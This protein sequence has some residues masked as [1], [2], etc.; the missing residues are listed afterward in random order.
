MNIMKLHHLLCAAAMSLAL[1]NQDLREFGFRLVQA[2]SGWGNSE[3]YP[4]TD[5]GPFG[6]SA[7]RAAAHKKAWEWL[8][9]QP[10]APPKPGK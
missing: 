3:P 7:V 9:K 1:R 2:R 10:A 6:T 5:V 8:D 4:V